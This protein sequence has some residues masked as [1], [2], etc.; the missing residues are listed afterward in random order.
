MSRDVA[1]DLAPD[2]GSGI[3]LTFTPPGGKAAR[4]SRPFPNL[5]AASLDDLRRGEP[6]GAVVDQLVAGISD[7]VL[8]AELEK[9]L[10]KALSKP[11][12]LRLIVRMDRNLLATLSDLP[13]ELITL[14]Q[15]LQPLVL[16]PRL[17]SMVHVLPK[18]GIP[19]AGV[20]RDWPLRVLI[21]RSNPVDL[22]GAVPPVQGIRQGILDAASAVPEGSVI[23]DVLSSEDD[24]TSP[25]TFQRFRETLRSQ[26]YDILVYL[27]HGDLQQGFDET[28]PVA[29]LQFES[30][31]GNGHDPI[32]AN[33]I[34]G[35]LFQ[36]PIRVVILA[37]CQT[38]AQLLT[39]EPQLRELVVADL[40]RW[41]RGAEG[42]AQAIIDSEAGVELAVGMRDQLEVTQ[43]TTFLVALFRSLV[44]DEPGDIERAIRAA[45]DD[46]FG[47]SPLPPSWS[48]A[49]MFSK[50]SAPTFSFMTVPPPRAAFS[51]ERQAR[52]DTLREL[53][54]RIA[55]SYL[56]AL[57][58]R[59]PFLD[60]MAAVAS[61][62]KPLVGKD[63]MLRPRFT[64]SPAG[65][66]HIDVESVGAITFHRL[67]A[68][69]TVAGGNAAITR[70]TPDPRLNKA[71]FSLLRGD[72]GTGTAHFVIERTTAGP[73]RLSAGRLFTIDATVTS[74]PPAIHEVVVTQISDD[75]STTVWPGMDL[76]A[77]VP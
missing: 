49:V 14:P 77:L 7:W 57:S 55:K 47:A 6:S 3:S 8:G 68:D 48:S 34:A 42:V 27:G 33:R 5:D 62:E 66:V 46:L 74:P 2:G 76:L 38:A 16:H 73:A 45:R 13:I 58:D 67:A 19:P 44:R 18:M 51:A 64:R 72:D 10:K 43:A 39:L 15:A 32:S 65:E 11:D 35:E 12:R 41:L 29:Y 71:G 63:S 40:P 1:L 9:R 4:F 24:P 17:D 54:R 59:T 60:M 21:A 52:L 53:R 69:V 26:V 37:G 50:G 25:A 70:L 56:E 22:G 28:N 75:G 20:P 23:V 30:A 61:D 31:D 36:H